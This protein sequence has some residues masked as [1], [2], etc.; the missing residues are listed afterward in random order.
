MKYTNT[1]RV[2]NSKCIA[3]QCTICDLVGDYLI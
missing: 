2:S 3:K 1:S